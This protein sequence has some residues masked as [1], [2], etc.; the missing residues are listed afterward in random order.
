LPDRAAGGRRLAFSAIAVGGDGGVLRP[1]AGCRIVSRP[2][3]RRLAFSAIAV[4]G[5]GGAA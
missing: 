4:G 3:G 2:R 5:H 1:S